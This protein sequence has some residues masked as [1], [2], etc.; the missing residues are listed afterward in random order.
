MLRA[1][2]FI[3]LAVD[4]PLRLFMRPFVFINVERLVDPLN[5][6]QLVIAVQNLEILRQFCILPMGFQQAMGKA[7]ES[8][9]PHSTAVDGLAVLPK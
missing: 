1:Q 8:A 5:Q 7:V 3:F 6:P 4:I 9:H 2:A